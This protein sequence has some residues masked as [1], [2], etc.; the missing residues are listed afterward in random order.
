MT[1]VLKFPAKGSRPGP[2]QG[3]YFCGKPLEPSYTKPKVKQPK[4]VQDLAQIYSE[5]PADLDRG[6]AAFIYISTVLQFSRKVMRELS[7]DDLARLSHLVAAAGEGARS[8][9]LD[10]IDL[11]VDLVDDETERRG[12]GTVA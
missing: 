3:P 1:N 9:N 6:Q 2:A 10:E 12:E 8:P 5:I 11:L 7:D 4:A